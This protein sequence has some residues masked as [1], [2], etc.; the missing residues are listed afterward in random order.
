MTLDS[1]ESSELALTYAETRQTP[2]LRKSLIALL[3]AAASLAAVTAATV[4]PA[5]ATTLNG[6]ATLADGGT[7]APLTSGGSGTL[8]TVNLP[9]GAACSGDSASGGYH[10]FSYLVPLGTSITG[11]TFVGGNPS[12]GFGLVDTSGTYYGSANTAITTGQI[13]SIPSDFEWAPLVTKDG[14]LS[15]L[16]SSG[17]TPGAWDAGIACA[18][19]SGALSD[20]WNTPVTFTASSSDP[21]GFVFSTGPGTGTPE[22]PY[23]LALPV[24]AVA[25]FGGAV[26]VRR[27][28]SVGTSQP[29]PVA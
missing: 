15:T 29:T 8:F 9:A 19:S 10:V 27:R 28:R 24:I 22:V 2:K 18:N 23:V 17:S 7:D 21:N 5:S 3:T 20:Y 12:A 13:I 25:V 26:V 14:L 11:L 16:L 4:S 6:V 1:A